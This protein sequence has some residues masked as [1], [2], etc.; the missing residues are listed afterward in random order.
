MIKVDPSNRNSGWMDTE[1]KSSI[2]WDNFDDD[3]DSTTGHNISVASQRLSRFDLFDSMH[4][5]IEWAGCVE[6][7]P[8]N[9]SL[10]FAERLD[11]FDKEAR[12]SDGD[13]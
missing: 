11:V 5:S 3:D 1:G 9:T 12:Q 7:R 10:P 4:N 6:A 8:H 13:S 2:S